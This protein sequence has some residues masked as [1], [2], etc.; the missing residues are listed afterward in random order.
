VIAVSIAYLGFLEKLQEILGEIFTKVFAPV[1]EAVL[2]S[3]FKLAGTLLSTVLNK[4]LFQL[5]IV[6]L[7]L[8]DFLSNIFDIFSGVRYVHYYDGGTHFLEV[9]EKKILDAAGRYTVLEAGTRVSYQQTYLLD[10]FLEFNPVTRVFLMVSLFAAGLAFLFTIYAVAKSI[11]DMTLDGKNPVGKIL[12]RAMKA[13]LTFLMIPLMV[14]IMLQLSTIVVVEVNDIITRGGY[15]G[16]GEPP[17]MGT[18]VFL[19][20]SLNAHKSPISGEANFT[21][22]VRIGYYNGTKH[23]SDMNAVESDFDISKFD[24]LTCIVCTCLLIFI[25]ITSVFL[26]VRRIFEVL[27]LYLAS[28]LFVS[29]MPLD[30]GKMFSQWMQ[31]FVAKLFSGFGIVFTMKVFMMLV[32]MISGPAI[33]LYPDAAV[34][35]VLKLFIIIGGAWATFKSQHLFLQILSP[36]AA[37]AAQGSVAALTGMAI[38]AATGGI[39]LAGAAFGGGGGG[40]DAGKGKKGKGDKGGSEGGSMLSR[41]QMFSGQRGGA[42]AQSQA[43]TGK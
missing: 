32:P 23:Y 4:M 36:E 20:G 10:M 8:L 16:G 42:P 26:F 30:D 31:S 40:Q 7:K 27:V 37:Q 28:P 9:A 43:F 12:G 5:E 29:T 18:I 6:L 33:T 22:S 25:M 35:S 41:E 21:D 17:T 19:S 3:L 14:F 38:G 24:I 2:Q 34:N 39:G 15:A 1:I 11:S 13:A